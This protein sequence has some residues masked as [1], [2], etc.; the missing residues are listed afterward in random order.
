CNNEES[1]ELIR[2]PTKKV[3]KIE[4]NG[5]GGP[6]RRGLKQRGF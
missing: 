1:L 4:K 3:E 6:M 2:K 5:D